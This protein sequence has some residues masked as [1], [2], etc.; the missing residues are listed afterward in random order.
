MNQA[1]NIYITNLNNSNN[2]LNA[3]NS[4]LTAN[5]FTKKNVYVLFVVQEKERNIFDQRAIETE[6]F[7]KL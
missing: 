6:L 1:M 4:N 3:I 7:D 5:F 2:L